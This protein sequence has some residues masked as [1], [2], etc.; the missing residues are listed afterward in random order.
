MSGKSASF[1]TKLEIKDLKEIGFVSFVSKELSF[2]AQKKRFQVV[3][4][5]PTVSVQ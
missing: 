1:W 4:G 5:Q 2:C 3:G